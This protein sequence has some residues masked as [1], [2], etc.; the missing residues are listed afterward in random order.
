LAAED[1]ATPRRP[2]DPGVGLAGRCA[3]AGDRQ[4]RRPR[5]WQRELTLA[6]DRLGDFRAFLEQRLG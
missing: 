4:G 2:L 3:E 6:L 5:R 1:G